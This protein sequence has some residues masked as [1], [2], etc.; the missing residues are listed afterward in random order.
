MSVRFRN[1][2]AETRYLS[3]GVVG[4]VGRVAEVVPDGLVEIQESAADS[5]RCQPRLWKENGPAE[6]D[7]LPADNTEEQS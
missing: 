4:P 1:V 7:I 3:Y 2:G 5:Y 6:Q